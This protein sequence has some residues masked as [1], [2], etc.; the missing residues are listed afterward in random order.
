LCIEACPTAALVSPGVLDARRCLAYLTIEVKGDVPEEF[1]GAIGSHVYGCDICQDVCPFNHAAP[2]SQDPAWQPRPAFDFVRLVDLAAMSDD[3]LRL[4]LR[5]S[6][7]K[8]TGVRGL[9][10]NVSLAMPGRTAR[11]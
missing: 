1:H 9:R 11:R 8:R 4:A 2:V 6:A 7:M 10:R 5:G 3:E